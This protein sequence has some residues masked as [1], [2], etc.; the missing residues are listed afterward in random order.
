MCSIDT[1]EKQQP[2][3]VDDGSSN[4]GN[5]F[6]SNYTT[7]A[8]DSLGATFDFIY[9]WLKY[10]DKNYQAWS[11]MYS[12]YMRELFNKIPVQLPKPLS[13]SKNFNFY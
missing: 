8:L 2:W 11:N 6:Q 7:E 9:C 10:F 13:H 3:Y 12:E 4:G 1:H 5:E